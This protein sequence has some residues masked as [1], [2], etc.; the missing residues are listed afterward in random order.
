MSDESGYKIA[1]RRGDVFVREVEPASATGDA[2]RPDWSGRIF[3]QLTVLPALLAVAWLLAGLPLLLIR[4]FSPVSMAITATPLA[5]VLVFMGYRWI[6]GPAQGL[7]AARGA[8][9]ARTPWWV[10]IALVAVAVAFGVDQLAYH[11]QQVI[12]N[13]DPAS[14]IQFGNWIS[15]HGSLPIPADGQAFGGFNRGLLQFGS[16]AFFQGGHAIVPQFMAGLPMLLAPAFWLGGTSAATAMGALLGACGV[17]VAGGLVG[18]L[19][20]PR[21][22]PL[23][24]LILAL[25]LPE[26]FTSRSTFSEPLAQLLFLGGLALVIDS[27]SA[28]GTARSW[29]AALGGVTLGLTLLARIDGLSDLLPLIPYCGLLLLGRARQAWPLIGGA[30]VGAGYGLVDGRVLSLPYLNSIRG[31]LDPLLLIAAAVFTLTVLAVMYRWR[32]GIPRLRT[33]RLPNLAA[34]AA[35]V[36]TIGLVVRPYVQTVRAPVTPSWAA[37]MSKWQ[38]AEHL[39]ADPTRLYNEI[40]LHWVFWYLGVPAVLLG[41]I[42]AALLA[43]R[44]LRGEAP[45]WALPLMSF[46][47]IIVTVL[48]RPGIVPDQPWASRRLVPAVLPGFIVLALW[49]VSWL[50][51]WL[52]QRGT[53]RVLQASVVVVLAAALT[54]PA[55]VTSWGLSLHSGGPVGVRLVADGLGDKATFRGEVAAVGKLCAAIP[56]NSSV[57]LMPGVDEPFTQVI[58]GMCGVP[59]AR[60]TSPSPTSAAAIV[61]GIRTAGRRPVLLGPS[62]ASV[63]SYGGMDPVHVLQLNIVGDAHTLAGPPVHTTDGLVAAWGNV[64]GGPQINVWMSTS[65]G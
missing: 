5:I 18:R 40:S 17:L 16:S 33:D 58:R 46:A 21:W 11:S 15:R 55:A 54:I 26:Q 22:A 19:V 13:R 8:P 6:T 42:G 4:Y 41:N 35:C 1:F 62:A 20:G 50:V 25:S 28:H 37:L 48:W 51:G 29:L 27:L 47:W 3:R 23:G 39:A 45:A 43:R 60:M 38:T 30:V 61:D 65:L 59:T 2:D 63:A 56:P 52:R 14:Y 31:S 53:H 34:A 9:P 57:L 36:V 44:C 32:E 49:A 10:I 64:S 12:I 24:A 7:L